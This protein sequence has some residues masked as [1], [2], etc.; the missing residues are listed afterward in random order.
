MEDGDDLVTP[1]IIPALAGNTQ[2]MFLLGLLGPDHP[3]SR[4]EYT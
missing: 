2:L 1:R 3:R 4:G